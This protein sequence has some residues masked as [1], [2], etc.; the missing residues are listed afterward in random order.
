MLQGNNDADS[1][2][3]G[4]FRFHAP[5]YAEHG[6]RR[7]N[8]SD[9]SK[10]FLREKRGGMRHIHFGGDGDAVYRAG[11][12]I[13]EADLGECGEAGNSKEEKQNCSLQDE[14]PRKTPA[15]AQTAI[16]IAKFQV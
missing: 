7:R 15:P 16:L 5:R 2:Y 9:C 13:V 10:R 11:R 14:R 6:R 8:S 12:G 1:L 4:N 3:K